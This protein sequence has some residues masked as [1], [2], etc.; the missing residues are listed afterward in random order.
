MNNSRKRGSALM[1]VLIVSTSLGITAVAGLTLT[2]NISRNQEKKEN[3][4]KDAYV[5]SGAV[6]MAEGDL[7]TAKIKA[8]DLKVYYV[9]GQAVTISIADNSGSLANTVCITASKADKLGRTVLNQNGGEVTA[10]LTSQLDNLWSYGV[11]SNSGL[12]WP[13]GSVVNG[14]VYCKNSPTILGSLGSKITKDFK[15]TGSFNPLGLITVLGN[16]LTGVAPFPFPDVTAAGY[17]TAATSTLVGPQ[18]LTAYNFPA[19]NAL[20][21]VNGNLTL[22]GAVKG[23]GTFYVTGNVIVDQNVSNYNGFTHFSVVTPNG[24]TFG[25]ASATIS[26]AGYYFAGTSVT[27][28]KTLTLT[29]ALA[30]GNYVNNAKFTVTWDNYLQT[31]AAQAKQLRAPTYWP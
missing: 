15:T 23:T 25:G 22:R 20:V 21:V 11:F 17:P 1:V 12:T 27:I 30:A 14:S 26:A 2:G 13:T 6:A 7:A 4:V 18:T 10:V 31:N 19:S 5:L 16:I 28:N 3:K 24:I 9:G 29:G 8:G